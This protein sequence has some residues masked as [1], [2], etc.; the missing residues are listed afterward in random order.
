MDNEEALM[1]KVSW[2]YYFDNMTQQSISEFLGISRMRVV[3][4]LDKARNTGII[5]FKIR[6]DSASRLQLEKRL[7][8]TYSLKD[9]FIVPSPPN[10]I[11]VN[12]NIAQAAAMYIN[13]RLGNNN[14]INM[15]Y[16]DTQS[17]I[18]NNLATMAEHPLSVVSMTGGVSYYLPNNMSTIFNA[19][20]YLIP[21]PLLVSSKE[22]VEALQNEGSINE[23]SRMLQLS[24]LSVVGIGSIGDNATIIKSGILSKN[25]LLYLQMKGAVGDIL[26]HFI[27]KDGNLV[28]T[29]IEERLITTSLPTLLNLNNVIGVAA[30][31][32]KV[33]AI[34]AVL[35]GGYI[36]ILITDESTALQLLDTNE[37]I[38]QNPED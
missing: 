7:A 16:G 29:N 3:K 17:R 14:F 37:E 32:D 21:S 34:K 9:T 36:D 26:C 12:E 10:E 28:E 31:D 25:D 1:I 24:S 30:G 13:N 18:L 15:G 20:L 8:E 4:L 23:V 38:L 22:V 6:E 35:K 27:D 19:K 33:A 5:Q 11:A 2:Y